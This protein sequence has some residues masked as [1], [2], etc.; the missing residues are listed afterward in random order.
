MNDKEKIVRNQIVSDIA[1][2]LSVGDTID[3]VLSLI[4]EK[5]WE[6]DFS[7]EQI[8]DFVIT[9]YNENLPASVQEEDDFQYDCCFLL[10]DVPWYFEKIDYPSLS[11]FKK[12]FTQQEQLDALEAVVMDFPTVEIQ[13][14][15]WME[16]GE[17]V[18]ELENEKDICELYV[19]S[20]GVIYQTTLV[21]NA[22]NGKNFS[23][24]ELLY[25]THQHMLGRNLG[26]SIFFEGFEMCEDQA[27]RLILGNV[28]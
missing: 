15:F 2:G 16:K 20:S 3:E 22:E 9:A 7:E 21:L 4:E 10:E 28:N 14:H 19:F 23:G 18:S 27:N 26:D 6:S 12:V 1:S 25:K 17:E 11:D 24:A 13:F 8:A 5:K